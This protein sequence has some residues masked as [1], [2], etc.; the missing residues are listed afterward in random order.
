MTPHEEALADAALLALFKLRDS[1]V[2]RDANHD[3]CDIDR[4]MEGLETWAR[5]AVGNDT[6]LVEIEG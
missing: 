3:A 1:L 2:L 5:Q 4:L 6:T